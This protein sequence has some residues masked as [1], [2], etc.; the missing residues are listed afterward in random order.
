MSDLIF[1]PGPSSESAH[2]VT[3]PPDAPPPLE[4]MKA[5][6]VKTV[7]CVEGQSEIQDA[8]RKALTSWGYRALVVSDAEQPPSVSAS[9]LSTP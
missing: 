3:E 8:L 1:D 4:E 2:P 7:L 6:I 9:H 5:A